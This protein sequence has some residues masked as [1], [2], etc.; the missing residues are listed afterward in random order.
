M[1]LP[2]LRRTSCLE[3]Y[4]AG[5]DPIVLII[6]VTD[7]W[8]FQLGYTV[9]AAKVMVPAALSVSTTPVL[10]VLGFFTPWVSGSFY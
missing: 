7:G 5:D 2:P 4:S 10:A 1:Q 6:S 8:F 9:L 3:Q